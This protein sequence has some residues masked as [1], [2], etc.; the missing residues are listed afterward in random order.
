[1]AQKMLDL[2]KIK[3]SIACQT[4]EESEIFVNLSKSKHAALKYSASYKDLV[5][6]FNINSTK[7]FIITKEMWKI[8]H[9]KINIID[10]ELNK[11][12]SNGI[13]KHSSKK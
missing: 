3:K 8:F 12:S 9:E 13:S 10:K 4:G 6:A 5:W 7:S 1:M 11:S 2:K